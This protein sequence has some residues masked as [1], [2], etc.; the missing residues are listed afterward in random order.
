MVHDWPT[1]GEWTDNQ[2]YW[3]VRDRW[4][5]ETLNMPGAL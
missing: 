5:L 1:Q 3:F 4:E 2:S